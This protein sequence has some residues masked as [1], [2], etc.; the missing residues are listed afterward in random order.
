MLNPIGICSINL[1]SPSSL[2]LWYLLHC[3]I[4]NSSGISNHNINVLP[5]FMIYLLLPSMDELSERLAD[6][7][8]SMSPSP[9]FQPRHSASIPIILPKPPLL[10]LPPHNPITLFFL[11]ERNRVG[12]ME[13]RKERRKSNWYNPF[14][15][16]LSD[17]GKV[18]SMNYQPLEKLSYMSTRRH[19]HKCLSQ[20]CI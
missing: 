17:T 5:L 2:F 15:R 4:P 7:T 10:R 3:L 6:T 9:L 14:W 11:K 1:L 20:H 16:S 12:G 13:K 8:S 18:E 19:T